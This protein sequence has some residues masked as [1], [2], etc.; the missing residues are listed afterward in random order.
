MAEFHPL[1]EDL[2]VIRQHLETI[3]RCLQSIFWVLVVTVIGYTSIYLILLAALK[4]GCERSEHSLFGRIVMASSILISGLKIHYRLPCR[5]A[6]QYLCGLKFHLGPH[7]Y[8]WTTEPEEVTCKNCRR[9][10]IAS[11]A[12]LL[13]AALEEQ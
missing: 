4:R 5:S 2:L 13:N 7:W 1:Q 6:K 3:S 12:S 11:H 10:L 8:N 9:K